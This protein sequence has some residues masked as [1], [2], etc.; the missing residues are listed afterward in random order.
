MKT[1]RIFLVSLVL[2]AF[3]PQTFAATVIRME[4]VAPLV[5][6]QNLLVLE[7]ANRVYQS[8]EAIQ[9]A[10]MNLLPRLNLWRWVSVIFDWTSVTGLIEDIAPF[11]V[12]ANWFRV[13]EYRLLAEAEKFGYQALLANEL[14]TAKSIYLT[15]LSDELLLQATREALASTEL[16]LG[17]ARNR[18]AMGSEPAGTAADLEIRLLG[19]RDDVRSLESLIAQEKQALKYALGVPMQESIDLLPVALETAKEVDFDAL[20]PQVESRAPE[21][22]QYGYFI[23][24]AGTMRREVIFSFL[25]ASSLSRGVNGGIFDSLPQSNGLGFGA[26]ASIRIARSQ[27]NNLRLQAMGV[28]EILKRQL[29]QIDIL[30]RLGNESL[31]DARKRVTMASARADELMTR[32]QLGESITVLQLN[33]AS[34]NVVEAKAALF[35]KQSE[36]AILNRRLER[37]LMESQ[38]Q[39]Q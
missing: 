31:V 25:G 18:E 23:R 6:K 26:G 14:L 38:Y 7:N 8:R 36:L 2:L 20:F 27:Q 33:D 21:L 5:R 28:K 39:A 11:L 22:A 13:R 3:I 9:V 10:R 35:T 30:G 32:L 37:L 17:I 29:Q 34:K 15:A 16:Q 4:D 19:L 1:M 24:A 12:P